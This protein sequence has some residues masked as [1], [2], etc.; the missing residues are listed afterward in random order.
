MYPDSEP[1]TCD[2]TPVDT[3]CSVLH[4]NGCVSRDYE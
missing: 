2:D 4:N 3:G 1:S